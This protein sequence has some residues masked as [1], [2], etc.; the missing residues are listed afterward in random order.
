MIVC[1]NESRESICLDG[2]Q[3]WCCFENDKSD[4]GKV[5]QSEHI[6]RVKEHETE[7]NKKNYTKIR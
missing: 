3:R 5:K 7:E 1:T 6:E 4:E 2:C